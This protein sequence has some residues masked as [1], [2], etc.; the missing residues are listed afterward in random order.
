MNDITLTHFPAT[1]DGW[2]FLPTKRY[3][4]GC[5]VGNHKPHA[6]WLSD[7]SA[8]G[9]SAWCEG[10]EIPISGEGHSFAVDADRLLVVRTLDDLPMDVFGKHWA[11]DDFTSPPKWELLAERYAGI[12]VYPSQMDHLDRLRPGLW[13][14]CWDCDS[15]AVWDL[16]AVRQV[17]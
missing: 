9:W 14:N 10:E 6:F 2:S 3:V 12:L 1:P 15:A 17:A 5:T 7:E 4:S 8:F 11:L 13:L 16:S